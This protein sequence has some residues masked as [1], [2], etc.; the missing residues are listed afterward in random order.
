MSILRESVLI[1]Y[2]LPYTI[3]RS[4]QGRTGDSP[5]NIVNNQSPRTK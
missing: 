1:I 4:V 2:T 5:R 3:P